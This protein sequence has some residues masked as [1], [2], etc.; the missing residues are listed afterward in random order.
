MRDGGVGKHEREE[1]VWGKR[2]LRGR[3]VGERK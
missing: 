2:G 3:R 1:E